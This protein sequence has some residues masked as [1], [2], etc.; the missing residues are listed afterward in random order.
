[1][2]HVESVRSL[3]WRYVL[4]QIEIESK[5]GFPDQ[6]P[7]SNCKE[8]TQFETYTEMR[9]HE[10]CPMPSFSAHKPRQSKSF[11]HTSAFADLE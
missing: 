9:V 5:V 4:I 6:S 1:M 3:S 11:T 8:K 7:E 2:L 10:L